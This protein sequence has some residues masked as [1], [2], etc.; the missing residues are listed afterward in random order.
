[1]SADRIITTLMR[2]VEDLRALVERWRALAE[3][4]WEELHLRDE[5]E[6]SLKGRVPQK[7][8]RGRPPCRR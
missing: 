4:L 2:Q 1:M 8:D 3:D 5:V 7:S 6:A